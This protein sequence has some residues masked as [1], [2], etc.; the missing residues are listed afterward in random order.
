MIPD[1]KRKT[2][3]LLFCILFGLF[4]IGMIIIGSIGIAWGNP[5]RLIFGTD[6]RGNVCGAEDPVKDRRLTAYPRVNEDFVMNI[7]RDDPA[8]YQFYG[9]CVDS[10]P[11]AMDVLCNDEV[12]A[13]AQE[14]TTELR[15]C[16]EWDLVGN[17]QEFNDNDCDRFA[18]DNCWVIPQK[19]ESVLFRCVP[20]FD[21][22]NTITRTCVFPSGIEDPNSPDCILVQEDR[23]GTVRQPA[24]DNLLFDQLNSAR[25]LWGRYFGDLARTWWVILVCSVV[26][27]LVL[28][29]VWL[30]FMKWCTGVMVWL[31]IVL[32]F[33]LLIVLCVFSFIKGGVIDPDTV[34]SVSDV[35]FSDGSGTV[36]QRL[37][38][39]E[40]SEFAF[41]VLGYILLATIV[42]SVAVIVY[43]RSRIKTAIKT[44]KMAATAVGQVRT[45]MVLP[46]TTVVAILGLLCWWVFV[47]ASLASAQ[48]EKDSSNEEGATAGEEELR[49]EGFDPDD[50]PALAR[51]LGRTRNTTFTVWE[52]DQAL[53]YMLIY[54][55]FGLLWTNQFLQ[56]ITLM[57][58]AITTAGWYFS[59]NGDAAV[60]AGV[61]AYEMK[62]S[63]VWHSLKMTVRYYLGSVALASLLIA[64]VQFIRA[65]MAY[66]QKSLQERQNNSIV[67]AVMCIVRLCLRCIEWCLKVVSR[68]AYVF[69][70]IKGQSFCASAGST[71]AFIISNLGVFAMVNFLAEAFMLLG[72]VFVAGVAALISFAIIENASMFEEGETSEVSSTWLPV[73]VTF[74]FGYAVATA[75]FSVFDMTVDTLLI[76]YV[77]DMEDHKALHGDKRAIHAEATDINAALTEFNEEQDR[78]KGEE[79]GE[80]AGD[81]EMAQENPMGK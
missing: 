66:V 74:I 72:K 38:T 52:D 35:A 24:K 8:D 30:L 61:G 73:L 76:C 79:A 64:I 39:S 18:A 28:G 57:T 81:V 68:N 56:G 60:E 36:S 54:H 26:I 32:V 80:G 4:W 49:R 33:V 3:D 31:T 12:S 69:M 45:L 15:Q 42:I 70:A 34:T 62:E 6:Y 67:Q 78:E 46:I 41:R 77:L 75:F 17:D 63:P 9:V 27:G 21:V 71:L 19:T 2:R 59:R 16:I 55:F 40:D 5:R 47:A 1:E 29:F 7:G 50:D 23:N 22:D 11:G 25:Q 13:A 65:V 44:I 10:C 14:N 58:I 48:Q 20:I 51:A 53:R 43:M 37:D